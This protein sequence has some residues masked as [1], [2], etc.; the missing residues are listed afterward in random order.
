MNNFVNNLNIVVDLKED[1]IEKK[2]CLIS[3]FDGVLTDSLPLID[4]YVKEIDYEA[5]DE[6]G[7]KLIAETDSYNAE[8]HR[9]EEERNFYSKEMKEIDDKLQELYRLRLR[10]YNHKDLVLEEVLPEYR[11][12][13][14][15]SKIYKLENAYPGIIE[16]IHKICEQKIFH[17]LYVCSSVNVGSEIASKRAFLQE[18][19]PMAKFIPVRFHLEPYYDLCTGQANKNRVPNDKLATL[20]KYNRD[21]DIPV[22]VAIDD[23][24]GVIER[25]RAIGFNSYHRRIEDDVCDIFIQASNDTI[26]RYHGGKIKKLSR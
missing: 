19:L 12:R 22:S 15:Y 14:D 9:L 25:G 20:V 21:I 11:G 26:D 23:T 3:D 13:I 1:N 7:R 2:C 16:L 18:H 8:K 17:Q 4:E 5:S 6:Y 10:H 24:K